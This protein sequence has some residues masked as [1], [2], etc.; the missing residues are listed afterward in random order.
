MAP[1]AVLAARVGDLAVLGWDS[2]ADAYAKLALVSSRGYTSGAASLPSCAPDAARSTAV[3][4]V[5][6]VP[7]L[8]RFAVVIR[9]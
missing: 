3:S 4:L 9:L 2:R 7:V 5:Q 8:V 6:R 1:G